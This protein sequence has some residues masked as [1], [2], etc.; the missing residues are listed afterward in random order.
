MSGEI[1]HYDYI[2]IL[3]GALA[4]GGGLW[5]GVQAARSFAEDGAAWKKRMLTALALLVAG[6]AL[7]GLGV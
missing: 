3:M 7:V 4:L 6:G 5:M 2:S 1:V